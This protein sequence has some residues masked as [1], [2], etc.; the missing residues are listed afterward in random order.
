MLRKKLF[1]IFL[2]AGFLITGMSGVASA[3]PTYLWGSDSA[4]WVDAQKTGGDSLM[5]WAAATANML[6]WSGWDGGAGLT[7]AQEIFGEF[8]DKWSNATGSPLYGTEW[9]LTGNDVSSYSGAAINPPDDGGGYYPT[10]NWQNWNNVADGD[11]YGWVPYS[12]SGDA[13]ASIAGYIEA[14]TSNSITIQGSYLHSL[15]VWGIDWNGS[16]NLGT[17]YVTD[18]DNGSGLDEYDVYLASNGHWWIDNYLG[19]SDF[20]IREIHRLIS[21]FGNLEPFLG[22]DNGD[23]DPNAPVPEPAT[24]ILLGTGLFGLACRYRKKR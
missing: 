17:L 22:G 12:N 16:S 20:E 15:T 2:C 8:N 18:S 7:S 13:M 3:V 11:V 21:N 9:W 14:G 23:P 5:C 4:S 24:L 19:N 10:V 6:A 1:V